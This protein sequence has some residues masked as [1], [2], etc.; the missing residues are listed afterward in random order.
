M[1]K[2]FILTQFFVTFIKGGVPLLVFIVLSRLLETNELAS[3]VVTISLANL[4]SNIS[5]LSA[6]TMAPVYFYDGDSSFENAIAFQFLRMVFGV[7]LISIG[8]F[9]LAYSN[10]LNIFWIISILLYQLLLSLLPTWFFYAKGNVN[11]VLTV[12]LISRIPVLVG[13]VVSL[14]YSDLNYLMISFV[15]G[16]L[17]SLNQIYKV[18]FKSLS[19]GK[20]LNKLDLNKSL[21]YISRV[22]PYNLVFCSI[23][24]GLVFILGH[25]LTPQLTVQLSFL[26]RIKAVLIQS[27]GIFY[28]AKIRVNNANK[29]L[30]LSKFVKSNV[31][32]FMICT[33]IYITM[34]A[35][36]YL[37]PSGVLFIFSDYDV[38]YYSLYF[39]FLLS[40]PF[41]AVSSLLLNQFA[42]NSFGVDLLFNLSK[43]VILAFFITLVLYLFVGNYM[44]L[45]Q[46]PLYIEIVIIAYVLFKEKNQ[47]QK[48]R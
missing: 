24:S 23:N 42:I 12:E 47:N 8:I 9:Y 2:F 31:D 1:S 22:L 41:N 45:M 33:L 28:L 13:I 37:Y 43:L 39:L 14:I 4:I 25:V 7:V 16:A 32:Y 19:F 21:K 3:V 29:N 48:Q 5:N 15:V 35:V 38:N 26:D 20:V 36:L 6:N 27:Q 17:I 34:M 10:E 46:M 11:K 40:C 30:R 44:F 18:F